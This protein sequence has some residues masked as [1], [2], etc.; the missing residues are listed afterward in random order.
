MART[1]TETLCRGVGHISSHL[2][3]YIHFDVCFSFILS[4]PHIIFSVFVRY[5]SPLS[6]S[7]PLCPALLLLLSL[8]HPLYRCFH[9]CSY[10]SRGF[11][12]VFYR[13]Q[14]IAHFHL[15]AIIAFI[16]SLAR[17]ANVFLL[18]IDEKCVVMISVV[19][20]CERQTFHFHTNI[21]HRC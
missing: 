21:V 3:A 7:V 8:S 14:N 18:Y 12:K 1:N 6:S 15:I 2:F 19:C 9:F 4:Q 11:V 5:C 13:R 10:Q 20:T 16:F 17:V